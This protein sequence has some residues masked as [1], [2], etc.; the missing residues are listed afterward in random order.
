MSKYTVDLSSTPPV[1][2]NERGIEVSRSEAIRI[3]ERL[4]RQYPTPTYVYVFHD[5]GKGLH[6]IGVSKD[7]LRRHGQLG[8]VLTQ[9]ASFECIHYAA[10]TLEGFIHDTLELQGKR[11]HGEW[12]E[13][14]ADDLRVFRCSGA[15]DIALMGR[16]K[17]YIDTHANGIVRNQRRYLPDPVFP[18]DMYQQTEMLRWG[19]DYIAPPETTKRRLGF[20]A[21]YTPADAP[22]AAPTEG[23]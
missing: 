6:K 14:N 5:Q 21:I 12:F 3:V 17:A 19:S 4:S 1:I 18:I 23:G 10:F 13:L 2:L 9:V 7:V 16:L 8:R 15:S 11:R 20:S 22:A